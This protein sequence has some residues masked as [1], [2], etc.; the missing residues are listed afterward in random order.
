MIRVHQIFESLPLLILA[1][2]YVLARL[3][4]RKPGNHFPRGLA[5]G[6]VGT[7]IAASLGEEAYEG[8]AAISAHAATT[9]SFATNGVPHYPMM[10]QFSGSVFFSTASLWVLMAGVFFCATSPL[11]RV[12]L[13]RVF[14]MQGILLGMIQTHSMPLFLGLAAVLILGL[15]NSVRYHSKS[16]HDDD[17]GALRSTA[18][19]VYQSIGLLA[20]GVSLVLRALEYFAVVPCTSTLIGLDIAC[21]CLAAGVIAGLFPFH[22]WV[23]PF[24]GSPRTSV[25]LP[26]ICVQLGVLFLL[27]IYAPIASIPSKWEPLLLGSAVIGLLYAAVLFFAEQR[28]KRIPGY[29]Y[30]SHISLMAMTIAGLGNVGVMSSML[31]AVNVLL[32]ILGLLG[33]CAVLTSRFGVRGVKAPTG[34]GTFF[35]ELAVCYLVCVLSLVGFPGTLG[36]IE[37]EVM[38]GEGIG[39]HNILVAI[40]AVAVTLNG[41]SSFRLFA[42]VFYGQTGMGRDPET[43]LLMRERLVI[44]GI[45]TLIVVNGFAPSYVV[46]LITKLSS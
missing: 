27:R 6:V 11:V 1:C 8:A 25:F 21:L 30:L 41:F 43:A 45:V 3:R 12:R 32:S 16:L 26:M 18:F 44:Y 7:A 40:F 22:G 36:F 33:V 2:G 20:L 19:T 38:M 29:L 14:L 37:E 42:R 15:I 5:F 10:F 39:H 23:L 28:L 4:E 13:S 31:D 17:R 35:P 24:L 9:F 34:L 46:D